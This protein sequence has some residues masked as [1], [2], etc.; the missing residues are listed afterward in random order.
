MNSSSFVAF[1]HHTRRALKILHTKHNVH[2]AL[3][4]EGMQYGDMLTF[5][6]MGMDITRQRSHCTQSF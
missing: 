5:E 6:S 1:L 4:Y 2:I 3:E